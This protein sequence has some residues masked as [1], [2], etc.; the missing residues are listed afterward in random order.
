MH[1]IVWPPGNDR[2]AINPVP[3]GN[4]VKPIK[5]AFV[6]VLV[7]RGWESETRPRLL[8]AEYT[9]ADGMKFGAEWETGNVSSSHR[10]INRLLLGAFEGEL[11]GGVLVV[12][13]RETYKYLTDR[14]GNFREL[15]RYVR[16][17]RDYGK[18]L[19]E[20]SYLGIVVFEHDALD[21]S[22]PTIKKGTDG[23]ALI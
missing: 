19:P 17:W 4:G 2:F 1:A 23:R 9:L 5:D 6:Q 16:F 12:P 3:K 13:S 15:E 8:D 20:R 11:H 10:A 14:V 7:G 18:V 21:S 22:V